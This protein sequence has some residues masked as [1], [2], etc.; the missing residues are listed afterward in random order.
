MLVDIK[1]T[2]SSHPFI[3]M[4]DDLL[5]LTHYMLIETFYHQSGSIR[6]HGRFII[7]A[8]GVQA[9]NLIVLPKLT[10][11]LVFNR[12]VRCEIYQDSHRLPRYI[13]STHLYLNPSLRASIFHCA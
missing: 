4:I 5:A 2:K 3:T 11:D 1:H 8:I 13:P 7:V 6:E 10:I 12:I 9:I